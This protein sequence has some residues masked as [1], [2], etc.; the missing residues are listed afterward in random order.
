MQGRI[1][2][3]VVDV[4]GEEEEEEKEEKGVGGV[5]AI[6]RVQTGRQKH[7]ADEQVQGGN[8]EPSR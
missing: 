6:L 4:D 1:N 7:E 5:A 3:N 8:R 2:S